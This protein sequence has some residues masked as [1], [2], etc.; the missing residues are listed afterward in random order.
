M[1]NAAADKKDTVA[2]AVLPIV[3]GGNVVAVVQLTAPNLD[4][5]G[6]YFN[7]DDLSVHGHQQ[8]GLGQGQE[9]S[10]TSLEAKNK[11]I[12]HM[13]LVLRDLLDFSD[14]NATDA[15]FATSFSANS[16]S[17]GGGGATHQQ[18]SLLSRARTLRGQMMY[19]LLQLCVELRLDEEKSV[20]FIAII[21]TIAEILGRHF[22][23]AQPVPMSATG[24]LSS[25]ANTPGGPRSGTSDYAAFS[26][27]RED[28]ALQPHFLSTTKTINFTSNTSFVGLAHYFSQSATDLHRAD[29]LQHSLLQETENLNRIV[30][31]LKQSRAKYLHRA[32]EL[33]S[34]LQLSRA[35]LEEERKDNKKLAHSM[36]RT[37]ARIK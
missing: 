20:G 21:S 10:R 27:R 32:E 16:S 37:E 3:W 31:R 29:T 2:T 9:N 17:G 25:F 28:I 11:A 18:Q 13:S 15:D 33:E 22:P 4:P 23:A 6:V 24:V 30:E 19:Q 34:E 35:S 26:P 36:K 12:K 14:V 1:N 5:R 8:Q 7:V